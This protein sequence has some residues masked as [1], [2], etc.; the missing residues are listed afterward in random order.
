MFGFYCNFNFDVV[1]DMIE[2]FWDKQDVERFRQ[3]GNMLSPQI[4]LG[5]FLRNYYWKNRH[6]VFVKLDNGD[7]ED[8]VKTVN[9]IIEERE[10]MFNKDE[11]YLIYQCVK[12]T[13]KLGGCIAELG[14]Y[15]GANAKLVS[16]VKGDRELHLFDTWKGL[17]YSSTDEKTWTTGKYSASY[18]LARDYLSEFKKIFFHKGV[19]PK[20]AHFVEN[21]KFSLVIIDFDLEQS[22]TDALNFFYPRTVQG[23]V[24]LIHDYNKGSEV[25]RATDNFFK[26]KPEHLLKTT[27]ALLF[28][29]KMGGVKK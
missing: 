13:N 28:I 22:I 9:K 25:K 17:P 19:F 4:I 5:N 18:F 16:T 29:Q 11:A 8:Y 6:T 3:S 7:V 14:A 26:G 23:G 21:K 24:I 1:L 27:N 12:E 2:L 10:L 15:Q 20:T